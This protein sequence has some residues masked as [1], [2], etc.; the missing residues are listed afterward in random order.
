MMCPHLSC[1][2][3][4]V[5]PD[6]ARGR[7]LRC[8]HCKRTFLVPKEVAAAPAKDDETQGNKRPSKR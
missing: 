6:A 5:A 4:V 2:R 3:T 8:A 1:G 7:V